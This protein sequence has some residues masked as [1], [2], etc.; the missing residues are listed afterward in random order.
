MT[1]SFAIF[2]RFLQRDAYNACKKLR[3]IAI[4]WGLLVPAMYACINGYLQPLIFSGSLNVEL[5][6]VMFVGSILLGL[7]VLSYKASVF[8]LFDLLGD[9]FIDYQM[10]LLNPRLVIIERITFAT[11]YTFVLSLPYYPLAKLLLGNNLDTHATSWSAVVLMLA[12]SSLMVSAYHVFICCTLRSPTSLRRLWV[13]C[14]GP[15]F[16]L[17]G[18]WVPWHTVYA[19]AP[20]LAYLSLANPF[21]YVTEGLR[22]AILGSPTFFPV[23]T[24][25]IVLLMLSL[26]FTLLALYHFKKRVDHI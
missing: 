16:L 6:T 3:D 15:L 11:L 24:C 5:N 20:W 2:L 14:N 26:I 25:V 4:N 1:L 21:M 8:I 23:T 19:A 18:F 12:A 10:T 9:R 7:Q 17:G 13:R 22:R